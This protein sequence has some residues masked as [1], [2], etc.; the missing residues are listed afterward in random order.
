VGSAAS[1]VSRQEDVN[2]IV[3]PMTLVASAGYL[4]GVYAAMGLLDIHAAWIVALSQVP[5]VS[6]FMMLGRITAGEA[7]AWE[8]LLSVV[9]LVAAII[10]ALWLAARIYAAGV[11]LYGQR[12]GPRE[13]WRVVRTGA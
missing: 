10:G 9:L 3:M 1:L 4:V 2:S 6:P 7:V 8:I 13:I 12:P 5:L 11:L